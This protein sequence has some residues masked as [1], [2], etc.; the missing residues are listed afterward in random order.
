MIEQILLFVLVPCLFAYACFSDLFTM[1]ISNRLCLAV[2]ALFPFAAVFSGMTLPMLG[3]HVAAAA[4]TLVVA[5]TLFAFGWI[6]GGTQSSWRRAR[7]GSVSTFFLSMRSYP[8]C[9]A[10]D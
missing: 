6:G 10:A 9:L 3:W 8:R 7:C 4:L 2:L 1:R 5:F